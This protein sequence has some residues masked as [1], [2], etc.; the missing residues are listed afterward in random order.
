MTWR[1]F[2]PGDNVKV[3]H[4]VVEE[5]KQ[6][7]GGEFVFVRYSK[8]HGFAVIENGHGKFYVHPESLENVR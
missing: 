7:L 8:P 1:D 3:V 2:K 6:F 4:A 5:D